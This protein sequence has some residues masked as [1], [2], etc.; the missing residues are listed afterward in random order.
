VGF[1]V[2]S[3]LARRVMQDL[4]DYGEV[5]RGSFGYMDVRPLTPQLARE[6]G[7]PDAQGVVVW[8][9]D[10]R[11]AAG[12]AGIEPGDVIVMFD[13]EPVRD[14]SDYAR[15]LSDAPIGHTVTLGIIRAG[16]RLG[17]EV[18]VSQARQR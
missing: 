12:R 6:L 11:S 1:A 10:Q 15:L 2:P 9:I 4:S 5:R 18:E 8:R 17:F 7:A 3:N 13:T 16:R 14:A